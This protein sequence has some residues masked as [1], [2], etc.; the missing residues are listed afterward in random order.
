MFPITPANPTDRPDKDAAAG[1]PGKYSMR[2]SQ[3][4]FLSDFELRRDLPIFKDLGILREQVYRELRLAPSNTEVFVF[5]FED[6]HKYEQFISKKHPELPARRAFFVAQPRRQ[7]G[8]DLM[9]Y[10]YW[11]DRIHQDLRHEL[12]HA[13]LHSVLKDVPLWLDEGLAEY[14]EVPQNW[15]GA[16]PEHVDKLRRAGMKFDLARLEKLKDVKDMTPLEYREA[17]AWVHLMLKSSVQ[18]KQVLIAYL[19]EL[20]TNA[21][22]GPL[23]PRLKTAYLSPENAVQT[24]LADLERK[25]PRVSSPT[26]QR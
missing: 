18:A 11:G 6:K 22:P 24:H 2:V 19:Q 10:T 16:N 17:W 5:L 13:I 9:V 3:F 14:F 8:E 26:A 20:R 1:T 21:D 15:N 12:T 4:I 7:G 23:Q 25:L